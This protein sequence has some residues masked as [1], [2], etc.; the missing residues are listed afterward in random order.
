[1]AKKIGPDLD[2]FMRIKGWLNDLYESCGDTI[3]AK[4]TVKASPIVFT[5]AAWLIAEINRLPGS[6][7]LVD[8]KRFSNISRQ[9]RQICQDHARA[10]KTGA[11]IDMS[12]DVFARIRFLVRELEKVILDIVDEDDAVRVTGDRLMPED[13]SVKIDLTDPDDPDDADATDLD[14]ENR[15]A[16]LRGLKEMAEV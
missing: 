2:T 1:M 5:N 15:A 3:R 10:I 16:A 6:E 14:D 4:K 13:K 7:S 12:A 9:V 11:F 8:M